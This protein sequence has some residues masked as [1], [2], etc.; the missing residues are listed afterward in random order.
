M[1]FLQSFKTFFSVQKSSS[2]TKTSKNV[3]HYGHFFVCSKKIYLVYVYDLTYEVDLVNLFL[4]FLFII[5]EEL[6][7]MFV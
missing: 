7:K 6:V 4:F 3:F 2:V 5:K 1:L